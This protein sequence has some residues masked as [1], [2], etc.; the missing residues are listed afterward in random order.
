MTGSGFAEWGGCI[1]VAGSS[2]VEYC[3]CIDAV[4]CCVGPTPDADMVVVSA[5]RCDFADSG[6]DG[7]GVG[8]GYYEK[9]GL[10]DDCSLYTLRAQTRWTQ[11]MPGIML[12]KV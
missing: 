5:G 10:F 11:H 2:F 12:R 8:L 3:G 1:A 7:F 4:D 6:Y 9:E